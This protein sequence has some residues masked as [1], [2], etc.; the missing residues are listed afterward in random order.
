MVLNDPG[1]LLAVHLL[2]T[3]LVSG[4]AGCMAAFEASRYDPTDPMFNPMWRQGMFVMPVLARLG[5]TSSWSGWSVDSSVSLDN[6]PI[7]VWTVEGVALVHICLAG[8]LWAS[9]LWHWVYWDLDV[10]RDRLSSKSLIDAPRLFGIHLTLA[11]LACLG[12]GI[13]HMAGF[14]GVWISDVFAL[15]GRVQPVS[16]DWTFRGFD[17]YNPAGITAHHIAAGIVGIVGGLFHL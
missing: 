16:P 2:H 8:L 11:G 9:A 15:G 4:W 12:F 7:P 5:V 13:F 17:V 1:R 14:P 6:S 3:G 10:F